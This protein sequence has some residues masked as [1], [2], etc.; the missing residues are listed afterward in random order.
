MILYIA[1][2]PSVGRAVADVL[3]RPHQKGDGYI[4]LANGDIVTW[5]IGHLLEQAEPEAYNSDYK[6][7]RKEDLPIIP[8]K[9]K[10]Q[11]KPQTKKQFSVVKK[12]IKEADTLVNMGDPD[13]VGQILVD[14]VINY[15]GV[16][17]KS[18]SQQSAV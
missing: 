11:V 7:W 4:K 6:K 16:S 8:E 5:C 18:S 12:L 10:H 15:V 1:E 13:R 9:W 2:K 3:P 14:E 17:K